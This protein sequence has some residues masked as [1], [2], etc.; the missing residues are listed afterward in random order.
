MLSGNKYCNHNSLYLSSIACSVK[1][2]KAGVGGR[3]AIAIVQW[4][5][6]AVFGP[7]AVWAIITEAVTVISII[8]QEIFYVYYGLFAHAAMVTYLTIS[9]HALLSR[10][11]LILQQTLQKYK[12]L[13]GNTFAKQVHH[14]SKI[15]S[16]INCLRKTFVVAGLIIAITLLA[17]G[18]WLLIED[19]NM[20][21]S[22]N[23]VYED[24]FDP[25]R[26]WN[27]N[28]IFFYLVFILMGIWL[29]YAWTPIGKMNSLNTSV[30][31]RDSHQ[32]HRGGHSR[33]HS[34]AHSRNPSNT[35]LSHMIQSNLTSFYCIDPLLSESH[36]FIG[37]LSHNANRNKSTSVTS[38]SPRN[39]V[40]VISSGGHLIGKSKVMAEIKSLNFSSNRDP[41]SQS[42]S[43]SRVST[44]ASMRRMKSRSALSGTDRSTSRIVLVLAGSEGKRQSPQ[45]SSS[46]MTSQ[47]SP[48]T[49]A[50]RMGVVQEHGLCSGK[51]SMGTAMQQLN[52][53]RCPN[54]SYD[55]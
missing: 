38:H 30:L 37:Q 12:N 43:R 55:V 42:Q 29:Y 22:I 48:Q 40:D 15:H 1:K 21:E 10:F 19:I 17:R 16:R 18:I 32:S 2:A 49:S 3:L 39:G 6:W 33:S 8:R 5:K 27:A 26:P 44:S 31:S 35:R 36:D 54:G 41:V 34:R 47:Q 46:R 11:Q 51:S 45:T 25:N 28:D 20:R 24:N 9:T 4:G 14:L 53:L 7:I 50:S 52:S 23:Q 13:R